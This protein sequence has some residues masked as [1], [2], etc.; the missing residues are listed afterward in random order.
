VLWLAQMDEQPG[1]RNLF[2]HVFAA[3]AM[4][5][6][7]RAEARRRR[8]YRGFFMLPYSSCKS[9]LFLVGAVGVEPTLYGF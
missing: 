4:T 2:Q 1:Y 9:T 6:A 3:L 8:P 5:D 7:T